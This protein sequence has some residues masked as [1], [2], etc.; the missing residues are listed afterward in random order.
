MGWTALSLTIGLAGPVYA[1]ECPKTY[2]TNELRVL[3]EDAE[4]AFGRLQ[5]DAF[6]A[7]TT[8]AAEILPCLSEPLPRPLAATFHRTRGLRLF[9]ERD[10]EGARLSFAAARSIEPAYR[11][12]TDLVPEGNPVLQEYG[13]VDVEAGTWLPLPEPEGRV[14][15]DG[16]DELSRPVDWP[17]IMQIFDIAGQVQQTVYLQPGD[18]T[19]EYNIRV[20]TLRD[21]IPPLL[22]PNIP[23]NPR[24]LAG[25]GGAALV[26]GGLYTAA[27]LSRRAFDDD[28]TDTDLIDPLRARTNGLVVATW[29]GGTAAVALGA[30]AFFVARW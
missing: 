15:F 18:P 2:Q 1:Q 9:V 26:A 17:T 7:A 20:I 29:V 10:I 11:F 5:L 14:T 8:Q 6:N 27:V 12:P 4:A 22:E 30:G 16:R 23:P 25:A 28:G 21:R 19:P 13:A 3:L 24:L